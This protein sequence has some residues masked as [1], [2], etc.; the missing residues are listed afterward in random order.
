[1]RLWEIS[2]SLFCHCCPTQNTSCIPDSAPEHQP[3]RQDDGA[4]VTV[5]RGEFWGGD[6]QMGF[7]LVSHLTDT[8]GEVVVMPHDTFPQTSLFT[9]CST[10]ETAVCSNIGASSA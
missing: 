7:L 4:C 1:M 2:L 9:S 10:E 8:S 6:M 3:C 5:P